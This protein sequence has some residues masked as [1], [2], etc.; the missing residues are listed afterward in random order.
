MK[1]TNIIVIIVLLITA[2]AFFYRGYFSGAPAQTF[3]IIISDEGFSPDPV[4]VQKG[5]KIIFAN[6]GKNPHWPASDFHPT[7]GI[8]PEFDPLAG[9]PPGE[10]WSLVLKPG[11]W[12][13]HDHLYPNLTGTIEVQSK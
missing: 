1:K 13:Y 4:T 6:N 7:H 2:G 10:E 3:T 12:H 9:I 11:R 5:T 8:Y